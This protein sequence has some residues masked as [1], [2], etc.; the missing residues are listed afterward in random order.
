MA[1]RAPVRVRVL[2]RREHFPERD[3]PVAAGPVGHHPH[4]GRQL[5]HPPEQRAR[6]LPVEQR[7]PAGGD[8]ALGRVQY[9][10][11]GP[12]REYQD[13]AGAAD[14][15][16][17]A[18]RRGA[19]PDLHHLPPPRVPLAQVHKLQRLQLHGA[20]RVQVHGHAAP[21]EPAAVRGRGHH[22]LL[23]E[24]LWVRGLWDRP[25]HGR[26]DRRGHRRLSVREDHLHQRHAAPL[27]HRAHRR[28]HLAG[29]LGQ[30]REDHLPA[31]RPVRLRRAHRLQRHARH[32]HQ[33]TGRGHCHHL[34]RQLRAVRPHH[35]G[36]PRAQ[37]ERLGRE[38][39]VPAGVQ[40]HRRGAALLHT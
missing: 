38:A 37:P 34:R 27:H 12:D 29:S 5:E 6:R 32:G 30:G 40:D 1:V 11:A 25:V 8:A 18:H 4:D 9:G 7:V 22:P 23:G 16:H 24:A 14:S 26:L 10:A 36:P 21:P 17:H 35:K 3:E 33:H 31:Q 28:G 13:R 19:G 39:V 2:L 20:R 15:V